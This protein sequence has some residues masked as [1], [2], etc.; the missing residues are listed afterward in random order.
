[1]L[2]ASYQPRRVISIPDISHEVSLFHFTSLHTDNL[3]H[4]LIPVLALLKGISQPINSL[5]AV[6]PLIYLHTQPSE[7]AVYA[8]RVATV[9]P[10]C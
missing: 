5:P 2:V 8:Q 10:L 3:S 7:R 1:M 4:L 9:W 6:V